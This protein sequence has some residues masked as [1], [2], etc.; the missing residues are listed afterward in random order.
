MLFGLYWG[1]T[2]G[3]GKD[4]I[5]AVEEIELMILADTEFSMT[6]EDQ[7]LEM[8]LVETPLILM[9]EDD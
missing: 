6:L 2:G 5:V 4:V 9:I 1:G 8:D 3:T 7:E